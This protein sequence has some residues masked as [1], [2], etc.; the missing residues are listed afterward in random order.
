MI[1]GALDLGDPKARYVGA[2]DRRQAEF[3]EAQPISFVRLHE[4]QRSAINCRQDL[5]LTLA[6][7]IGGRGGWQSSIVSGPNTPMT[8]VPTESSK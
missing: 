2:I 7:P 6:A 3:F 4:T 5:D 8:A 1:A